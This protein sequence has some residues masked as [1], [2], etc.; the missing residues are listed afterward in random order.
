MKGLADAALRPPIAAAV[1]FVAT[2]ARAAIP[3]LTA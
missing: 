3:L 1:V 2:E